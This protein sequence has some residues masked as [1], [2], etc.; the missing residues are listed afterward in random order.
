MFSSC[1]EMLPIPGATGEPQMSK[2]QFELLF[3]GHSGILSRASA[4]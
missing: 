3:A 4:R 1:T 2:L